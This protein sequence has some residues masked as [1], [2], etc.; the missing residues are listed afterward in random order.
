M[1]NYLSLIGLFALFFVFGSVAEAAWFETSLGA[2]A[3]NPKT[4]VMKLQQ[5]LFDGGYL[6]AAPTGNYLSLTT[7]AVKSFQQSQ[8]IE[9][10]GFFGPLTRA[11]ANKVYGSKMA[12]AEVS[13]FSVSSPKV[14]GTASVLLSQTK[15]IKWKTIN[16]PVGVGVNINLLRKVGSNPDEFE[17]V[18]QIAKDTPNDGVEVWVKNQNDGKSEDLY[19]EV[20]CSTTHAFAGECR[21][22]GEAVKAF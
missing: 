7:Q 10:T 2:G 15:E 3:N 8:G 9:T 13:S 22:A 19:I 1:K 6:K 11:A 18:R 20:T 21:F 5:F 4:E 12:A 16:Y 14:S 17:L